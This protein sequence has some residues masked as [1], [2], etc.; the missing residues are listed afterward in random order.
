ML[1]RFPMQFVFPLLFAAT[2]VNG[3]S[4]KV[5]P[6][7]YR[8]YSLNRIY[9]AEMN[10]VTRKTS[11]LEA[12]NGRKLWEIDGWYRVAAVSNDGETLVIGNDGSNLLP[13]SVRPDEVMLTFYHQGTNI[14]TVRLRELVPELPALRK[15]VS[16]LYWGE[17]LGFDSKDRFL[18]KT[19]EGKLVTF[20]AKTGRRVSP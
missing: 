1:S 14:G 12:A 2:V 10:H 18:L 19:V 5:A 13:M 17:Y 8:V 11:V 4:P 3:D 15:T 9:T 16:H 6:S 7:T 20:D